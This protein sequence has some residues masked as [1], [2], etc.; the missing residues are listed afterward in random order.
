MKL[1]LRPDPPQWPKLLGTAAA[2]SLVT[3]FLARNFF[4]SEKKI[5]HKIKANYAIGDDVFVRTMGHL[6]GPPL[7]DGNKITQLENGEQIFPAMLAGIRSARRTITM[8]NFLW[9]EGEI[10]DAFAAALAERAR[11]GVKVHF[12]QDALGSDSV[13]GRAMQV[14]KKAGVAVEIFR[15]VHFS[16]INYRTHRKILVIDGN[17]GFIGGVGIADDWKGNGRTHGLWRDSHYQVEGPVVAQLQQAFMDN[18]METR[19]ELLHDDPYFPKQEKAGDQ[20]C[21]IFKSSAG[22]GSDSARLML[23]V[24]IAAARERIRIANAYFI[25]GNLTVR[26]LVD[27]LRRG[28]KVDIIT[29]G[30][31]IDATLV[32]AVGKTRWKPLLEAGARFYEY[33]PA[34]FHCKYLLVDDCWASVG[35]ANLDNRSMSLN[36]EANLNVLDKNF[37][38]KHTRVFEDDKEHSREVTLEDWH[39][40]PLEEKIK[41][42]AMSIFRS[43]M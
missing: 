42:R 35:S 7:V 33:Q 39:N 16:R 24:S 31:D 13:H 6:L 11:A 3:L 36:E 12:L 19:A 17:L 28:V 14:M 10:S 26:T 27:A 23:L 2:S 29:P 30:A 21:Q 40:R 15:F 38:A 20:I 18:W 41:G 43:Q 4:P 22:E 8:E 5:R 37:V 32:R 34:R 1:S 25:P 9:K